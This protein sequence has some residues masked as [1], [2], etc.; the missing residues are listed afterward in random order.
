MFKFM[1]FA[2]LATLLVGV[3][4]VIQGCGGKSGPSASKTCS[5]GRK[6][7]ASCS[8]DQLEMKVFQPMKKDQCDQAIKV[9]TPQAQG[10]SVTGKCS[11][12]NLVIET[13]A[14]IPG[15]IQKCTQQDVDGLLTAGCAAQI[16][17]ATNMVV[18]AATQANSL[19]EKTSVQSLV[20]TDAKT[21]AFGAPDELS[22]SVLAETQRVVDDDVKVAMQ[23]N[24]ETSDPEL[25]EKLLW[26]ALGGL[27][28]GAAFL[29]YHIKIVKH[30]QAREMS[31]KSWPSASLEMVTPA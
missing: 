11:G 30:L 6:L 26:M 20:A 28:V 21:K 1:R 14:P 9:K 3:A 19:D 7:E 16:P 24:T 31:G 25:V 15:M 4:L 13:K 23:S 12:G 27:V 29:A 10:I 18:F 2:V 8:N 5:D 17:T 22:K